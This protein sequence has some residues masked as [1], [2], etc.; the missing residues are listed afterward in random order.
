M[1]TGAPCIYQT[2]CASNSCV[3]YTCQ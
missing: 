2:D 1:P 3:G